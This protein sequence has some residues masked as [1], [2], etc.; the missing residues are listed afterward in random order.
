[1]NV[2]ARKAAFEI[3]KT[4]TID[5]ADAP[6]WEMVGARSAP[7]VVLFNTVSTINIQEDRVIAVLGYT[8]GVQP[9]TWA[10]FRSWVL[11]LMVREHRFYIRGVG[12]LTR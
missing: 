10:S 7:L 5:L 9:Q 11:I 1:M 3:K 2:E 4:E 8:S 6:T 12:A